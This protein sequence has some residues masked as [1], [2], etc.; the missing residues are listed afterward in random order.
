MKRFAASIDQMLSF[1]GFSV[2]RG[3]DSWFLVPLP[4]SHFLFGCCC[5]CCFT[6]VNSRIL[7]L[8]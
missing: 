8:T 2:F 6:G 3:L 4:C 1:V 7:L 5:Y